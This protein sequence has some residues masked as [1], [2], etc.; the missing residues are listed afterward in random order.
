M[1]DSK[2]SMKC[3]MGLLNRADGSA[4]FSC[5]NCE[6]LVAVYGPMECVRQKDEIEDRAC[7]RV[8]VDPLVGL[9]GR[10][11]K[12]FQ[13]VLRSIFESVIVTKKFPRMMIK[14]V[15]Q[16]IVESSLSAAINGVCLA[17]LDAGVE[18]T[19]TV[20][21]VELEIDILTGEFVGKVDRMKI[22]DETK[23]GGAEEKG[24]T[25]ICI[26]FDSDHKVVSS[27]TQGPLTQKQ[28][29]NGIQHAR[30]S[31]KTIFE[32]YREMITRRS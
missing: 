24:P 11:E 20:A 25:K 6:V 32:F 31:S 2:R 13:K 22:H 12:G 29:F 3:T 23:E 7:V 28:Y 21:A 26:G 4:R 16:K 15:V 1:T 18:M 10:E 17:L 27:T 30:E 5:G 19:R 8:L 14:I 9:S